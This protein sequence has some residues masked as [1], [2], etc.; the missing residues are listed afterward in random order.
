M[1]ATVP[2]QVKAEI[3]NKIE[4]DLEEFMRKVRTLSTELPVQEIDEIYN[5][6]K[7]L[8]KASGVVGITRDDVQKD[9]QRAIMDEDQGE[10]KK[11][12][13][14][15][16][17][18]AG[19]EL[20]QLLSTD[21]LGKG[22]KVVQNLTDSISLQS[23][24]GDEVAAFQS[25]ASEKLK[26]AVGAS[27]ERLKQ[28]PIEQWPY[29]PPSAFWQ[30][31]A[32]AGTEIPMLKAYAS[33]LDAVWEALEA[34]AQAKLASAYLGQG[35]E[36]SE[37]LAQALNALPA[38]PRREMLRA[39]FE[40]SKKAAAGQMGELSRAVGDFD[41]AAIIDM[42]NTKSGNP[43]ARKQLLD[44]VEGEVL[45]IKRKWKQALEKNPGEVSFDN[46]FVKEWSFVADLKDIGG[47]GAAAF[48]KRLGKFKDEMKEALATSEL[49]ATSALSGRLDNRNLDPSQRFRDE[50][51]A[52][53]FLKRVVKFKVE[54]G[55]RE[56]GK[57]I[58]P[59]EYGQ[60]TRE[61]L[62][63][64]V[65]NFKKNVKRLTGMMYSQAPEKAMDMPKIAAC[66]RALK[67]RAQL[68]TES[69]FMLEYLDSAMPADSWNLEANLSS[70][71]VSVSVEASQQGGKEWDP[72]IWA[73]IDEVVGAWIIK[74]FKDPPEF[75]NKIKISSDRV[76]F[77][78][79][80][81]KRAAAD[82]PDLFAMIEPLISN[83]EAKK[84]LSAQRGF[85]AKVIA[86]AFDLWAA[87]QNKCEAL[88]AQKVDE[89][90]FKAADYSNKQDPDF[91]QAR[92]A[93]GEIN[94]L[95]DAVKLFKQHV[96]PCLNDKSISLKMDLQSLS[97]SLLE[98]INSMAQQ[99]ANVDLSDLDAIS[100]LLM[101][102]H[103]QA[104][105]LLFQKAEVHTIVAI[106]L[107]NFMAG[108]SAAAK[109][110]KDAAGAEKKGEGMGISK[111][112]LR[113]RDARFRPLSQSLL[114]CGLYVV[115][116]R[117]Y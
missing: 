100:G 65:V 109:A 53:A 46:D 8:R 102:M 3:S 73:D 37:M 16:V 22:A 114:Y 83:S 115:N 2:W 88:K 59:A 92:T 99:L 70:V 44:T 85:Q 14:K 68:Y 117:V 62:R 72:E 93:M 84:L 20:Q 26:Q 64:V 25:D 28:L 89:T 33:G 95:Y 77:Y 17:K 101:S 116:V 55:S 51:T 86:S 63:Q 67:E 11:L 76:L 42:A 61:V 18:E 74:T 75:R 107:E 80:T 34:R 15:K 111:L 50:S 106:A 103:L 60:R 110:A 94:Q 97:D 10:A 91:Q 81:A 30:L 56:L 87:L 113:L 40:D 47:D 43:S 7:V 13:M 49:E 108:A 57:A 21:Q 6:Y 1:Q 24:L 98:R 32:G 27:M 45:K 19:V 66:L 31:F 23:M 54:E 52:L 105:E 35:S 78:Q 36:E 82:A 90:K 41:S 48:A 5:S 71:M 29:Q 104:E 96:A 38:L 69:K 112:G 58:M 39:K 4:T 79:M 12:M 9:F